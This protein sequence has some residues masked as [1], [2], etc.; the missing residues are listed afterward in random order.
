MLSMV[1]ILYTLHGE[2][3]AGGGGALIARM[4]K[5]KVNHRDLGRPIY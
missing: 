1:H 4:A 5:G 3:V 2:Y